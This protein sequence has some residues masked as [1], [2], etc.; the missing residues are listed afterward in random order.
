MRERSA[1]LLLAKADAVKW[2]DEMRHDIERDWRSVT[3]TGRYE[4]E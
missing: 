4:H 1:Q 2:A 3:R